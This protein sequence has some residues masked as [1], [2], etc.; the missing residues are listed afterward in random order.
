MVQIMCYYTYSM[1]KRKKNKKVLN[2][3]VTFWGF[4]LCLFN[5]RELA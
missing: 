1:W 3:R 5:L 4:K 2:K